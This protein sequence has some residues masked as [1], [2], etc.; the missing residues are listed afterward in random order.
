MLKSKIREI[1]YILADFFLWAIVFFTPLYF[2]VFFI[3]VD[4]FE[5]NKLVVFRILAGLFVFFVFLLILISDKL[6]VIKKIL[7]SKQSFAVVFYLVILIIASFFSINKNLSFFGK[8]ARYEG[9]ESIVCYIIF[10]FFVWFYLAVNVHKKTEI[11]FK[12]LVA[13]SLSSFLVSV[14][15]I[16]Q[17]AGF[18]FVVW[19]DPAVLTGRATSTLGQPNFLGSFLLLVIPV[20]YYLVNGSRKKIFRLAGM[21]IILSN[22]LCLLFT[23]SRGGWVGLAVEILIG[24]F[25]FRNK[26][27]L[28]FKNKFFG[29]FAERFK[30]FFWPIAA[31][32]FLSLSYSIILVFSSSQLGTRVA[33]I[34]DWRSGSSGARM[35]FW[36]ASVDSILKR[37]II[38]YGPDTQGEILVQYYKK[39]WPTFGWVNDYPD[40]AHNLIIDIL[41]TS[42]IVGLASY[43]IIL[44]VFFWPAW[45]LIKRKGSS[46]LLVFSLSVAIFG[47]LSSLLFSFSIVSTNVYFWLFLAIIAFLTQDAKTIPGEDEDLKLNCP[48]KT[49]FIIYYLLFILFASLIC[50]ETK[51]SMNLLIADNYYYE[52]GQARGENNFIGF[53]QIAQLIKEINPGMDYYKNTSNLLL[54]NWEDVM[55]SELLRALPLKEMKDDRRGFISGYYTDV[56]NKARILGRL[57]VIDGTYREPAKTAF[58]DL[59]KISP[60]MP[61]NYR[62]YAN[63]LSEI[64]EYS[65]AEKFYQQAIVNLPDLNSPLIN[66]EH[67]QSVMLERSLSYQGLAE[68]NMKLKKYAEA[69][70]YYKLA[71][72]DDLNQVSLYKKIADTY[73]ARGDFD[74]AIWYNKHGMVRSPKDYTWPYVIAMLYQEKGDKKIA[75]EYAEKALSLNLNSQEIKSFVK[76][77]E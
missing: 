27:D 17:R 63:F 67:C 5:L 47:Y 66:S 37:P 52:L 13:I 23:M 35:T 32:L 33:S 64:G 65:E 42:G 28:Y 40:R 3:T 56:Y 69:E 58:A 19:S 7:L 77:L 71:L 74:K 73:Y 24:F 55:Q 68:I 41:L 50:W 22:L 16:A 72:L 18:D 44:A 49:R 25:V 38:G 62:E 30:F 54:L 29:H 31:I 1:S 14:Y 51:R 48:K 9:L 4:L 20:N 36:W 6:S 45:L 11:I 15:G 34:F 2:S 39:D 8:Y 59:L 57:A 70:K 46:Y 12:L 21:L 61:K 76:S 53:W 60:E 26:I 43:L 75:L 10:F